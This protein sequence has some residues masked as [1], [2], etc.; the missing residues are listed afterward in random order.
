MC[1][2]AREE[3]LDELEL[4]PL[5]FSRFDYVRDYRFMNH[6]PNIRDLEKD[7]EQQIELTSSAANKENNKGQ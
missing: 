5:I 7:H 2:I 3:D 6:V 4:A 1:E